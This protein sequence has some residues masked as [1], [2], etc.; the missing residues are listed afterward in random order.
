MTKKTP[1]PEEHTDPA[2]AHQFYA[3]R[4]CGTIV[5]KNF[6]EVCGEKRLSRHDFSL[7]HFVEETFEGFTHFDNK[8]FR[9]ARLLIF[10][11]GE[12]SV[13]FFEG[14]KIPYMRPFPMFIVC[15]ILFFMLVGKASTFSQ[16]LSSFY[17]YQPYT[18]FNTKQII[19]S[20]A[21]T[22][23]EKEVLAIK[24]NE[25]MGSDSKAY[26]ALF[27]PVLS[28][29]SLMVFSN[30]RKYLAEHMVFNTHIFTF[31]VILYF[32]YHVSIVQPYVRLIS[33]EFNPTFDFITSMVFIA[34]IASYYGIAARK[35]F[36]ANLIRTI[37]GS[38]LIT[39]LFMLMT[40]SYRMLLFYKIIYSI[41]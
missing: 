4:T 39:F 6:C 12:L 15:N 37:L 23:A 29:G 31:I 17:Q 38:F 18:Y 22:N 35:F 28:L 19:D 20:M 36:R 16:P 21:G 34:V 26:L 40:M 32:F 7:K 11:P 24:F 13:S 25:M 10:K 1:A 5:R 8:F 41:H 9:T 30:K 27:I 14:R 3:C 33:R 2:M